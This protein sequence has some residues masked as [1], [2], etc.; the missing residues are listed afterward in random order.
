[1]KIGSLSDTWKDG[2]SH[3]VVASVMDEEIKLTISG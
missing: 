1:M 3:P 2:D